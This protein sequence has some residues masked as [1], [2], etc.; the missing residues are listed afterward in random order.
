MTHQDTPAAGPGG[1]FDTHRDVSPEETVAVLVGIEEYAAGRAWKLDGPVREVRELAW[2]LHAR[3]VPPENIHSL[4]SPS[5][6]P[7]SFPGRVHGADRNDVRRL[8]TSV[9]PDS[10]CSMLWLHWSGHGVVGHDHGRRLFYADASPADQQNLDFD[11]LLRTLQSSL[12]PH[13]RRLI[14]CV[15]ACAT[16]SSRL[17]ARSTLPHE[18]LPRGASR[19]GQEQFVLFAARP[20]E[21]AG[22]VPRSG[23]SFSTAFLHALSG[24]A[25]WPPD[26]TAVKND[27]WRTFTGTSGRTAPGPTYLWTQDWSDGQRVW[28][29]PAPA[30]GPVR[31]TKKPVN[32]LPPSARLVG[33][34]S[35]IS[36]LM[37]RSSPGAGLRV[38]V[39]VIHGM[40]G[41]GKTALA[42]EFADRMTAHRPDAQIYI[43]LHGYTPGHP[44]LDPGEALATL[45]LLIGVP[46]AAIPDAV[47]DRSNLW[48]REMSQRRAV[49]VIDNAR[50]VEHVEPLLVSGT[51]TVCV[52]TSRTT[53]TG[54]NGAD[55][56]HLPCL[57]Q[58]ESV[59][60]LT[61]LVG[62]ERGEAEP[63][64]FVRVVE[65]VS[66]LPL[67]L[68]LVGGQLR[69]RPALRLSTYAG[70]LAGSGT[71]ANPSL[72]GMD[73]DKV[74][75]LSYDALT[76]LAQ[77]LYRALSLH[78][79]PVFD[80]PLAVV[81]LDRDAG[82]AEAAMDELFDQHL[83]EERVEG[84][85][86]VHDLVRQ[87]IASTAAASGSDLTRVRERLHRYWVT[88]AEAAARVCGS[89]SLYDRAGEEGHEA[90]PPD[91][92]AAVEWLNREWPNILA[93][94]R[95]MSAR[96]DHHDVIR[97]AAALMGHL[98]D[99][100][101][102]DEGTEVHSLA[103]ASARTVGDD[104]ARA[105]ALENLG[106][107]H[108]RGGGFH[109]AL[110]HLDLACTA[111]LDL[112]DR[113]GVARTLDRR[114]FTHERL[115]NYESA[116]H[117]LRTSRAGFELLGD[118]H[119]LAQALNDTGAVHWRQGRY[120]EALSIFSRALALREELRDLSGQAAT[121]NNIGFTHHRLGDWPRAETF[122]KRAEEMADT[123]A[124]RQLLTVVSNNFGYLWAGSG[125]PRAALR[126]GRR[127]LALAV[128]LGS[129]YQR[130]RALDAMARACAAAGHHRW[131]ER[132][133]AEA[134]D[135]FK[136]LSVPEEAE[137]RSFL[138]GLRSGPA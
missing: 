50:D 92:R 110:A 34:Q 70:L 15:D 75:D 5:Q 111:W 60:L 101:I 125:R 22:T 132:I 100:G 99:R 126:A 42:V 21:I 23:A 26:M 62:S 130:A 3:G 123:A 43:D 17:R 89:P 78:S 86:S 2:W 47:R 77:Q 37:R 28:W 137:L 24:K 133:G 61:G 120:E 76:P 8:I 20:G 108:L 134:I 131:A 36:G 105:V 13:L 46:P 14:A 40:P 67:A 31:G 128:S 109:Q 27:L 44:R 97:L 68:H 53:L 106:V 74:F 96:G 45:L 85:F 115:G 52:V 71:A 57:T 30:I 114:G 72:P 63:A 121:L 29:D 103:L 95:T 48:R 18:A 138:A 32:N 16:F 98:R 87:H 83:I 55:Y 7:G 41:V 104:H 94:V 119:G 135:Q 4:V 124:D 90:R 10:A 88:R 117:D 118:D 73:M 81:L 127:G 49:V 58:S 25:A 9:V 59:A 107:T 1:P 11:D 65:A 69:R 122:L 129:H 56:L 39:Q 19:H 93:A 102:Y 38:P 113:Q 35:E 51:E 80:A 64:A 84:R 6:D 82:E 112:G 91:A 66:G 54:L 136:R 33:R 12:V 79:G 116:L